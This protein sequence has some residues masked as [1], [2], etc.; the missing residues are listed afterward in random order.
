MPGRQGSAKVER[1]IDR[2]SDAT[3]NV[4]I[5]GVSYEYAL[6]NGKPIQVDSKK[7]TA[8]I[9]NRVLDIEVPNASAVLVT[10]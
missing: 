2:G 6:G 8:Q 10:L 3:D 4:T 9:R 1:L 5:R 7:E